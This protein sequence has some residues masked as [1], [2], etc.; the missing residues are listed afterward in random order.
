M[1]RHACYAPQWLSLRGLV[2]MP[3]VGR[4]NDLIASE[5]PALDG[6]RRR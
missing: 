5:K 3:S 1:F 4:P 2:G 6:R